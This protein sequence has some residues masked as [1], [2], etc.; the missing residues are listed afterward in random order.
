MARADYWL[1][2]ICDC[3][4]FYDA[5][6]RYDECRHRSDG[7]RLPSGVGD[8]LVICEECA[9]SYRVDI[10]TRGVGDVNQGRT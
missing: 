1:C 7:K 3:K 9:K 5:G 4:T 2:D 6:L 8:M 10:E